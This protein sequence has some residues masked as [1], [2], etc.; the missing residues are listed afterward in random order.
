M[1]KMQ[2]EA[3][4]DGKQ[5]KRD[6]VIVLKFKIAQNEVAQAVRAVLL[7]DQK[8]VRAGVKVSGKAHKIGRVVVHQ[9]QFDRYGECKIQLETDLAAST[10]S[11]DVVAEMVDQVVML[12]VFTP[13][14]A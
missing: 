11:D 8:K 6:G 3:T 10:L 9:V 2:C 14:G 4:F 5:V 13:E 12:A 1:A 7:I